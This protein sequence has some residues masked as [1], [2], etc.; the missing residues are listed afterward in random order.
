MFARSAGA[1]VL[2]MTIG[3]SQG[4]EAADARIDYLGSTCA[5]C[6]AEAEG[7]AIRSLKGESP[8]DILAALRGFRDKPEPNGIMAAV[9]S[10]LDD[11]TLSD[12]AD[13][14]AATGGV[15]LASE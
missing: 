14:V 4:A 7:G 10:G 11:R 12:L 9:V 15:P 6:H 13:Y 1:L 2:A 3:C 5:T 8:A